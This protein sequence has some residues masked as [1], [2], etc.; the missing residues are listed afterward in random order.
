MRRTFYAIYITLMLHFRI[1]YLCGCALFTSIHYALLMYVNGKLL[2]L[3]S[4]K[5]ASV[6]LHVLFY[7]IFIM[8]TRYITFLCYKIFIIFLILRKCFDVIANYL[9]FTIMLLDYYMQSIGFVSVLHLIS[10][11]RSIKMTSIIYFRPIIF[12]IIYQ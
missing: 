6:L 10:E 11:K 7:S 9:E 12:I 5:I 4:I 2:H 1:S 3:A 8:H